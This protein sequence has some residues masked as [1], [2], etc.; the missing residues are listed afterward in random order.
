MMKIIPYMVLSAIFFTSIALGLRFLTLSRERILE[1]YHHWRFSLVEMLPED[2]DPQHDDSV[3][4]G[5]RVVG[6]LL[7]MVAILSG[8]VAY[9]KFA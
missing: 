9:L 3:V 4:L 1:M 6:F 2:K 7:L 5:F 8:F